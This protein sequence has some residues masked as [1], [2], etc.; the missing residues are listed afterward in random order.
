MYK[1]QKRAGEAMHFDKVFTNP[2]NMKEGAP[3]WMT[4]QFPEDLQQ[5][6]W[7][8][9]IDGSWEI[10]DTSTDESFAEALRHIEA[11]ALG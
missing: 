5:N 6:A 9:Y 2:D 4:S 8:L 11:S 1:S 3:I 10:G 7:R